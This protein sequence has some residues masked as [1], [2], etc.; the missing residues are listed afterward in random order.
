LRVGG[1]VTAN[2]EW[3]GE[4]VAFCQH[5]K[6]PC[7]FIST[8][9]YPTDA[10]GEPGDD[11][12]KQLSLATRGILRQRVQDTCA[13]A[14]GLPVYY[15]EWSSSSNP[16]FKLHDEPYAAAFMVKNF[17]DIADL[18]QC[19]SWWTFSDIFAEN[20]FCSVPFHG[21]FGLLTIDGI[22]KPTYR[23][24]QLLCRLGTERLRVDGLHSTV[25]ATVVRGAGEVTVL[26]TNHAFPGHPIATER[27]TISLAGGCAPT[28]AW[29]ERIDETHCN[30]RKL[31]EALGAPEYPDAGQ[32]QRL[33]EASA[34]QR[35]PLT[36]L[37]NENGVSLQI[38]LP[39]HA[40]AAITLHIPH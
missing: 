38:E 34:L 20:Y 27:V 40:V 26:L 2:D 10:F 9:H 33:H 13:A 22:A 15:T 14:A 11:T 3:I 35:E 7:D 18:V 5:A 21:G 28:A 32:R 36:W 29:L 12:E 8:H 37:T 30:P 4:F 19:Y 16:F 1:P 39:V 17:L 23:A 31:W 6:L 25:D 24:F